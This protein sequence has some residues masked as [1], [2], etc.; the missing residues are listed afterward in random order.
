[1]YYDPRRPEIAVLCR[2][3]PEGLAALMFFLQVF[4]VPG[5]VLAVGTVLR[6]CD[7]F[8]RRRSSRCMDNRPLSWYLPDWGILRQE[9]GGAFV[10]RGGGRWR[11]A[12][13]AFAMGYGI[14]CFL[15]VFFAIFWTFCMSRTPRESSVPPAIAFAF[16]IG[17]ISA[18]YAWGK[19]GSKVTLVC[20]PARG[21][22]MLAG[23]P[24][25]EPVNLRFA[26]VKGFKTRTV[27]NTGRFRNQNAPTYLVRLSLVAA[28]SELKLHDF[29]TLEDAVA[30][31]ARMRELIRQPV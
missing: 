10:L 15:T 29:Q 13:M 18:L 24:H 26:D 25:L 19:D 6:F 27:A 11:S 20:H 14:T 12:A 9:S 8:R 21:M 4:I 7:Y 17:I 2:D 3:M 28:S 1:V 30:A 16:V 23:G 31:R 5:I 22:L